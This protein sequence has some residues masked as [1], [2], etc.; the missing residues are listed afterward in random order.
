[1]P[2]AYLIA[3]MG[4]EFAKKKT[5]TSSIE[6]DRFDLSIEKSINDY[7]D[8]IDFEAECA[9]NALISPQMK[10][11]QMGENLRNSLQATEVEQQIETAFTVLVREG[12]E[13]LD[14]GEF[15][16]MMNEL[17][18]IGEKMNAMSLDPPPEVNFQ[19]LLSISE[20]TMRSI[21]KVAIS[22]FANQQLDSALALFVFLTVLNPGHPEYWFRSGM[23]AHQNNK[24]DI[25]LRSYQAAAEL[26]PQL[27]GAPL[28]MAECY[29]RQDK[30]EEAKAAYAQAK[31]IAA[32]NEV[33]ADWKE[34]LDGLS[35]SL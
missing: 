35:D 7:L 8:T 26:D 25:A 2:D 24:L 32:T 20:A 14:A 27:I 15:E 18:Q 28:L 3:I 5:P 23:V 17:S 34:L 4:G 11:A 30:K 22:K 31:A 9:G 1:M 13:A 29:L 10:R 21:L 19:T 33:S 16:A 12:K 6:K